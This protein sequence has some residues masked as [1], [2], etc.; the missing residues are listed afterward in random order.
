SRVSLN[1]DILY[2]D[3]FGAEAWRR[4]PFLL[5]GGERKLFGGHVQAVQLQ[6][7]QFPL[8]VGSHSIE[9]QIPTV[10]EDFFD[11]PVFK[12]LVPLVRFRTAAHT[13]IANADQETPF[14]N[15]LKPS[16]QYIAYECL[17]DIW[18]TVLIFR[19]GRYVV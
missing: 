9:I 11:L 4:W 17:T 6:N 2:K 15:Q 7:P 13:T 12:N 8:H 19:I 3:I 18:L 10:Q 5:R 16:D 1:V 14:P